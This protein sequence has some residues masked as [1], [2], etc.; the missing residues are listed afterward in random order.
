[1]NNTRQ[2]R[3]SVEI[4]IQSGKTMYNM[5]QYQRLS[6]AK[7]TRIIFPRNAAL[8]VAPSGTAI[9]SDTT[10]N[11]LYLTLIDHENEK[12]VDAEPV[13]DFSPDTTF[14]ENVHFADNEMDFTKSFINVPTPAQIDGGD[15]NKVLLAIFQ[16]EEIK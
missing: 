2:R 6:M 11:N 4:T 15:N 5:G 1:M 12:V 14:K 13:L 16:Y 7:L 9:I 10:F 8:T 3:V